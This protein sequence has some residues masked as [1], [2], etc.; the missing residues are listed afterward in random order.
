MHVYNSKYSD[1]S[2][3]PIRF[4]S[5]PPPEFPDPDMSAL[6]N[7]QRQSVLCRLE[8]PCIFSSCLVLFGF[9]FHD[10][11]A[12]IFERTCIHL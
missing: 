9:V 1:I 4:Q 2:L 5:P 7:S 3:N 12:Y 8:L 6:S 11:F 10:T